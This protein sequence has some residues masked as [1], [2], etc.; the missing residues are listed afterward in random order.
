MGQ[1]QIRPLYDVLD[2]QHCSK[3]C[4]GNPL[5]AEKGAADSVPFTLLSVRDIPEN[6]ARELL[7]GTFQVMPMGELAL[8]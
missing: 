2:T 3:S 6:I 8:G 5:V 1:F 4:V 7:Y